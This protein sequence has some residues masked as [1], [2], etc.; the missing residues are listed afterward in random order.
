MTQPAAPATP[1]LR[2]P[3]FLTLRAITALMLR[4]MVSTYGRSPGGYFW[5]VAQPIGAITVL[6]IAFSFLFRS[7]S[8]GTSFPLFYATGFLPYFMFLDISSKVGRSLS[9]SRALLAYPTVTWLDALLARFF[10][11]AMAQA[12]V[13]LIVFGGIL[14]IYDL[15]IIVDLPTILFAYSMVL[16][17]GMGFGVMNAFLFMRFTVWERIYAIIMRPMFFLSFVLFLYETVP[18]PYRE[19]LWWNPMGHLT[20][21]MRDGFYASYEATWVSPSY[22]F[23]IAFALTAMGLM[24]LRKYHQDL[25]SR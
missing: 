10:L 7:P 8:L 12:L 4:E 1:S 2:A 17:L 13:S 19:W 5:A 22:V 16:A 20:G 6:A 21:E 3:K 14:L 23:G 15:R 25:L 18:M 24:L 9:F 11:N